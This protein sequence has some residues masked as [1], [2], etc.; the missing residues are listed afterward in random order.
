MKLPSCAGSGRSIPSNGRRA[1]GTPLDGLTN[2]LLVL[3]RFPLLFEAGIESRLDVAA[4]WV[5]SWRRRAGCD[6][7]Q[8]AASL[9]FREGQ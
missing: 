1:G 9:K 8:L 4:W 2:A 6:L 3:D 5:V 7:A